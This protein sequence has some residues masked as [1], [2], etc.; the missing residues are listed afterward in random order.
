MNT[1][2]RNKNTLSLMARLDKK[3]GVMVYESAATPGAYGYTGCESDGYASEEE[4]ACAAGRAYGEVVVGDQY[5]FMVPQSRLEPYRAI[6]GEVVRVTEVAEFTIPDDGI[7]PA[8]RFVTEAGAFGVAYGF[9]LTPV[10]GEP[11]A[12]GDEKPCCCPFCGFGE[13][14]GE[15]PGWVTI[16]SECADNTAKLTEWQCGSGTCG[17]SFWV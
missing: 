2:T 6:S 1:V 9:E 14:R 5:L 16:S 10:V 17:R 8:F 7:E 15:L 12:G 13:V 4:A 11:V 3:H